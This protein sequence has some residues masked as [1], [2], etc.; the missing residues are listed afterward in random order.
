MGVI[1]LKQGRRDEA[2]W[3][4]RQFL[5]YSDASPLR[6]R[7]MLAEQAASMGTPLESLLAPL[8]IPE[9]LKHIA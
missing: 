3:N 1:L 9:M 6:D 5:E 8:T 7:V 4:L 2:V